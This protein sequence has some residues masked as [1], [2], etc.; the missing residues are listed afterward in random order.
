M[1]KSIR[2]LEGGAALV[3]AAFLSAGFG[4]LTRYLGDVWSDEA[5]VVARYSVTLCLFWVAWFF[6]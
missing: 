6:W 5:Q 4:L 1:T 2:E 3:L